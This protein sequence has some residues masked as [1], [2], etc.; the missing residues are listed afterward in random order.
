[1]RIKMDFLERERGR[2]E[3]AEEGEAEAPEAVGEIRSL[4]FTSDVEGPLAEA[5][6]SDGPDDGAAETADGPEDRNNDRGGSDDEDD[7]S[8]AASVRTTEKD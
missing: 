7:A 4:S 3:A 6:E 1:M 2:D 5:E 8:D